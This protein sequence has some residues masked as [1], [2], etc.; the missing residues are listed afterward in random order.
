MEK[1]GGE[2]ESRGGVGGEDEV[3]V[4]GEGDREGGT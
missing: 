2:R 1:P 3:D 4:E